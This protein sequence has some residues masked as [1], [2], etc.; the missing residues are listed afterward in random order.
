[1]KK[2]QLISINNKLKKKLTPENKKKYNNL[3]VALRTK[4]I[5]KNSFELETVLLEILQD[6]LEYQYNG[7]TFEDL[8]GTDINKT[9]DNIIDNLKST[10]PQKKLK[11]TAVFSFFLLII[12]SFP[13][14]IFNKVIQ[15]FV[16]LAF[17][18]IAIITIF[19]QYF[20]MAKIRKKIYNIIF[21]IAITIFYTLSLMFVPNAK[22]FSIW[23]IPVNDIILISYIILA[24]ISLVSVAV[25][26][27]KDISS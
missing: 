25:L 13:N 16:I 24:I 23:K 26:I 11:D 4:G 21:I 3:V 12:I 10:G 18:S 22:I 19:L 5:N 9:C 14:I 20:Y 6:L 15:P 8:L 1:M 17:L 27:K 2:S 7:K